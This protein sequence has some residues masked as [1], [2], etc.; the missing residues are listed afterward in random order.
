M[1]VLRGTRIWLDD[2]RPPPDPTWIVVTTSHDCI[3]EI[4]HRSPIEEISLDHDLGDPDPGGDSGYRVLVWIE[5]RIATD[6]WFEPPKTIRVHTANPV[7]RVRMEAAVRK[8]SGM[9]G[10][11]RE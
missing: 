5:E 6:P 2:V 7:A 10:R 4:E 3:R 8:I 1:V 9:I 11:D